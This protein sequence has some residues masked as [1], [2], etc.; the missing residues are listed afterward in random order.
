MAKVQVLGQRCP[1]GGKM[2]VRGVFTQRKKLYAAMLE[3]SGEDSWTEMELLDDVSGKTMPMNYNALCKQLRVTGR[4][5]V[6]GPD[7]KREFQVI[8]A[9]TNEI[10][11]WDVDEEGPR[12]NPVGK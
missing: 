2:L 12:C 7:G 1:H 6:L 5:T 10:R 3:L 8:D 11:D 4:A 9:A